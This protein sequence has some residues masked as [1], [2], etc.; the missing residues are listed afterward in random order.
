MIE[1]D[2]EI[3][4]PKCGQ[5]NSLVPRE[6]WLDSAMNANERDI[7]FA[8]GAP[9]KEGVEAQPLDRFNG[10]EFFF[11]YYGAMAIFFGA[12][13]GLGL[14]MA[15]RIFMQPGP[16]LELAGWLGG[17]A[18]AVFGIAKAEQARRSGEML[19]TRSRKTTNK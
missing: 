5:V 15:M 19:F 16:G 7:C 2:R 8:C 6:S 13:G 1:A 11:F 12:I 3:A 14:A 10:V 17:I 4:C 18:G 9:L